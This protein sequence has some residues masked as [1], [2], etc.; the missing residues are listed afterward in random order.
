[1]EIRNTFEKFAELIDK[2]IEIHGHELSSE[3]NIRYDFF[4]S[5]T[6][7]NEIKSWEILLEAPYP[8]EILNLESNG[9]E[10]DLLIKPTDKIKT[11][12][13][14]EFKYDRKANSTIN[15]T[16]RYG[17]LINDILRLCLLKD[18]SPNYES[19]FIYVSDKEMMIYKNGFYFDQSVDSD[20]EITYKLINQLPKSAKEQLNPIFLTPFFTRNLKASCELIFKR[21]IE[22]EGKE[23]G[24]YAWKINSR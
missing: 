9:S 5:L 21:K 12:L 2:R 11:G 20:F 15:K 17:K 22:S 18:N 10:I 14:C 4:H 24:I 16:N 8:L 13:I 19:L 7:I 1:M 6:S 3:D 23:Y